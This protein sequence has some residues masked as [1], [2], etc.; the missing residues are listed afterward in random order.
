MEF[1]FFVYFFVLFVFSWLH[2][3]CAREGRCSLPGEGAPRD[4]ETGY[5]AP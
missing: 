1:F 4:F 5:S 2:L 3:F